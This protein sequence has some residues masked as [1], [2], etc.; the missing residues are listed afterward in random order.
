MVIGMGE[1]TEPTTVM[2]TPWGHEDSGVNPAPGDLETVR[3]FLSL[4]DHAPGIDDSFPPTP[5]PTNTPT[6]PDPTATAGSHTA[7]TTRVSVTIAAHISHASSR[8]FMT[9]S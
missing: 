2:S 5:R 6:M 7:A 9:S 8:W 1:R 4:H 3:S